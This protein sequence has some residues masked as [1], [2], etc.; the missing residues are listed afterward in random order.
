MPFNFGNPMSV[1]SG[2]SE[3]STWMALNGAN[4]VQ[5][6]AL[7][8]NIGTATSWSI[9]LQGSMDMSNASDIVTWS[10]LAAGNNYPAKQ[11]GIGFAYVRC[12]VTPTGGGPITVAITGHAS[13]Q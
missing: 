11:T 3:F 13:H 5:V 12:K 7:G 9:V 8:Y 4:A 6:H 2:G 10:S 1:A